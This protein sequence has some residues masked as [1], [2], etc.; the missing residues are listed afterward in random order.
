MVAMRPNA[1]TPSAVFDFLRLAISA[2]L[3]VSADYFGGSEGQIPHKEMNAG[4]RISA[5]LPAYVA[6]LF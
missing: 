3:A 1:A 2:E 6:K 4:T 5:S